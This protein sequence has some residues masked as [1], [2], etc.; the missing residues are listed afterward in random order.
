MI[1]SRVGSAQAWNNSERGIREGI[2]YAY[3]D[4]FMSVKPFPRLGK[5][6]T[7]G[8]EKVIAKSAGPL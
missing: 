6:P 5:F 1:R 2:S 4:I 3:K 8:L 7:A